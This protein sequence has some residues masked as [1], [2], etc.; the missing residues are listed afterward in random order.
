MDNQTRDSKA[1]LLA[2]ISDIREGVNRSDVEGRLII[3]AV[4]T[5]VA[6]KDYPKEAKRSILKE[7]KKKII[8]AEND[9]QIGLVAMVARSLNDS[10]PYPL[11]EQTTNTPNTNKMTMSIGGD[12]LL[13]INTGHHQIYLF[14][15]RNWCCD[16]SEFLRD[17]CKAA[18]YIE[19]VMDTETLGIQYGSFSTVTP[20]QL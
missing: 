1:A 7:L 4:N 3:L 9:Y 10:Q 15:G 8:I 12:N 6:V 2:L 18:L 5:A 16:V 13:Q 11:L 20:S 17:F 14:G 19:R